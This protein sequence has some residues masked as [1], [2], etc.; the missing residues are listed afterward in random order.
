M[1]PRETLA[2]H[3]GA[4]LRSPGGMSVE[5]HKELVATTAQREQFDRDGYLVIDDVASEETLDAIVDQLRDVF[6]HPPRK[7]GGVDYRYNRIMDAWKVNENVKS[8]ALSPPVL[9]LLEDLYERKPLPFQTLDFRRGT[10]QDPHSDA[11]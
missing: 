7:E 2:D 10:E 11:L 3:H 9:R 1:G 4:M 6:G 5:A 8:L